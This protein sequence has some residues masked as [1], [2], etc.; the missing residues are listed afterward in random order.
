MP[1]LCVA[2]PGSH[3]DVKP[4]DRLPIT[5]VTHEQQCRKKR[6]IV[7]KHT[8]KRTTRVTQRTQGVMNGYFGGY[9]GKGQPGGSM[10]TRKCVKNLHTLRARNLGKGKAAQLR[11]A[12]GRLITDLEMN[13]TYRGAV[14]LFNLS[15]NLLAKDVLFAE[16][17]RAFKEHTVDGRAW[18]YRLESLQ[19]GKN[20][21]NECLQTFVPPTKK[22][23]VRSDRSRANE[24]ESYA[25]RPLREPW[26]LLSAYEF[27]QHW[28]TEPLLV[29]SYYRN[30][31][32]PART[33]WTKE[34]AALIRTQDYKDGKV[35]AK[36]GVHYC[37]RCIWRRL[38]FISRASSGDIQCFQAFV[39]S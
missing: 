15:R 19:A 5:D 32:V 14:E 12:S 38:L 39:G 23:N 25:Y 29:P 28:R 31:N 10:E 22:T 33:E 3:S 34:G 1:G 8:L 24:F 27:L 7:R 26:K 17:T 2:F 6:C 18:L 16:C 21:Q 9:I 35:V 36:P 11:S 30:R 37:S 4:N 13:S 20:L